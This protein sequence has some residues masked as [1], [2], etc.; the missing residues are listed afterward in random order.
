MDNRILI[1]INKVRYDVTDFALEH[2]GG[3]IL[4]YGLNGKDATAQFARFNHSHIAHEIMQT[5]RVDQVQPYT[6]SEIAPPAPWRIALGKLFTHEDRFYLHKALGLICLASY[7]YRY[8]LG[9]TDQP[10]FDNN[11]FAL[12]TIFWHLQLNLTSF[13]FDIPMERINLR[14]MIWQEF[15]A[16]NLIFIG[17]SC[18]AMFLNWFFA[19]HGLSKATLLGLKCVLVIGTL[20]AADVVSG[21]L[22]PSLKE[23]TTRTMPYWKE[24][25]AMRMCI[26]KIY[27]AVSQFEATFACFSSELKTPFVVMMPIQISSLLMTLVRKNIISAKTWHELYFI[28]LFLPDLMYMRNQI[29]LTKVVPLSVLCTVLRYKGVSKYALWIAIIAGILLHGE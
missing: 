27:Y 23:T 29:F 9:Y 17:R 7:L 22:Q 20:I 12:F 24:C 10:M 15:R 25:S 8:Y 14:P 5:L 18:V 3:K 4:L 28:S 1:T 16:H 26:H 13:I 19:K 6:V 11:I 21:L 2:P